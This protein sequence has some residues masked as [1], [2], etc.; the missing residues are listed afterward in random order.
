MPKFHVYSYPEMVEY[1][2]GMAVDTE[3]Y[4][5]DYCGLGIG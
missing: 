5:G 4:P 2:D 3:I 1:M